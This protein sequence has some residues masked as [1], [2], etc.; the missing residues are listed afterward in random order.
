M[1]SGI[2]AACGARRRRPVRSVVATVAVLA[3]CG[4]LAAGAQGL[5]G[6]DT[7]PKRR[8]PSI[9]DSPGWYPIVDPESMSVLLGRRTN[10]PLVGKPFRG[11]TRSLDELGRAV[12]RLLRRSDGDSLLALCIREEEFRDIMWREFPHSRPITGLTWEDGW[13]SLTQRLMAGCSGAASDHGGRAFEY[14]RFEVDSVARY[15][16]FKLHMGLRLVVRDDQGQTTKM[17]WVRSVAER[18]R[19]FKIYSTDD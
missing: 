6:S 2:S 11:G 12:C 9:R 17:H 1:K 8:V 4:V 7:V 15:K 19:R 18:K 3:C 13:M 10:A 14:L 16:N 5:A